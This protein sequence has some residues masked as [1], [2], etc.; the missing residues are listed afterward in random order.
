MML[1]LRP[2]ASW[3]DPIFLS[4]VT[5]GK[6]PTF[7]LRPVSALKSELLPLLGLP[8]RAI[9]KRFFFT[10]GQRYRERREAV[11]EMRKDAGVPGASRPPRR[12]HCRAGPNAVKGPTITRSVSHSHTAATHWR[13]PASDNTVYPS[14]THT[15]T[16]GD[17]ATHPSA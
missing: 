5:P 6:L 16:T 10:P 13:H 7:W 4:T 17:N 14:P 15:P 8:T 9:C 3:V 2:C 12:A 1:A 11:Y